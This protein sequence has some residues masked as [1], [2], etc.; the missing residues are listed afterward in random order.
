MVLYLCDLP[1]KDLLPQANYEKIIINIQIE[2]HSTEYLTNAPPNSSKSL[3]TRTG[4]SEPREA[5]GDMMTKCS[6]GS[7]VDKDI[8]RK[9]YNKWRLV[10][11]N[12]SMF[13]S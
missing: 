8:I 13:I 1:A 7:L 9:I 6:V 5:K 4:L 3:K 11:S 10:H 12:A 2:E